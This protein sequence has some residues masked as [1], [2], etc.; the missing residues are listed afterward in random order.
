VTGDTA[1][2]LQLEVLDGAESVN[3]ILPS[4]SPTTDGVFEPEPKHKAALA[5]TWQDKTNWIPSK[6]MSNLNCTASSFS[7]KPRKCLNAN[8]F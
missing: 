1:R 5:C 6:D 3:E 2:P 4:V 8:V 7:D